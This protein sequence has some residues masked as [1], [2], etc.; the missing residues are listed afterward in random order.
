MGLKVSRTT[1]KG[2]RMPPPFKRLARAGAPP[3]QG[4]AR[5]IRFAAI[6]SLGAAVVAVTLI[7]KRQNGPHTY[8]LI[9]I[10]LGIGFSVMLAAALTLL[11][12]GN[13]SGHDGA[14]DDRR[15]DKKEQS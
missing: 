8:V 4:F 7:A 15:P 1:A 3:R 11:F 13:K 6:C 5:A 9:A 12:R 10:A 14:P 2:K